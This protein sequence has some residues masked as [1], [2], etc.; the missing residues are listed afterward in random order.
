MRRAYIAVF[1][2]AVAGWVLLGPA[3]T[4]I[5]IPTLHQPVE[6]L[7]DRWGVPH[8][9][10]KNSDDL[11]FA[12]GWITARDRLFQL[13]LWRR[14]GSGKLAE[15]LGPAALARD[16][17]ARLLRYRGDLEK[18]WS[19]YAPDTRQI[20]TAF[21]NGINAYIRTLGG[22]RPLEFELAGYDPGE[23]T[24]EDVLS[25]MAGLQMIRNVTSE[26][27]RSQD[28]VRFGIEK[29]QTYMPPDPMRTLDPPKDVDLTRV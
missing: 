9:Y 14:V 8:I 10:A 13:D 2:I 7:I 17:M 11:F 4:E 26:V 1:C 20:V 5:V 18:E 6:V 28:V 19:S 22:K 23:W 25:R 15:V 27:Q 12:Q 3:R 29:V 16:R 24:P 21:V